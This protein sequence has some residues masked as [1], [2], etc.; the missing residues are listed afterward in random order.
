MKQM[1]VA[2]RNSNR[3]EEAEQM[4]YQDDSVSEADRLDMDMKQEQYEKEE[5]ARQQRRRQDAALR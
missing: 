3:Y 4:E 5:T 2:P 1:K